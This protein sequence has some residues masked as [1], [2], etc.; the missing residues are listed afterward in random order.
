MSF[1]GGSISQAVAISGAEGRLSAVEALAETKVALSVYDAKMA[2]ID[3]KDVAQDGRLSAVEALAS[4]KVASATYSAKMALVDAKDAEHDGKLIALEAKDAEHSA[5]LVAIEAKDVEQDG[6]LSAVEGRA[7]ALETDISGRVQT[8]IDEKVAQTVFD[9]LASELRSADSAL[10]AALATKVAATTQ[11]S[12]D[13]LQDGAISTKASIASLNNV[14]NAFNSELDRLDGVDATKVAIVDYEA[15][16]DAL[17]EFINVLLQTYTITK[18]TGGAYEYTGVKQNLLAP[19]FAPE[20]PINI[21]ASGN[22]LSFNLPNTVGQISF[23]DV[24][25]GGTWYQGWRSAVAPPNANLL[26]INGTTV[27]MVLPVNVVGGIDIFT[28]YDV[29]SGNSNAGF[30]HITV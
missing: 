30:A 23:V 21:V 24:N 5:R 29:F 8:A 16:V 4:S 18:P 13:A 28:R 22:A 6:R 1:T 9:S 25:V 15:K 10:T 11:A 14:I 26:S 7:T 27:A 20:N 2:L 12:V 3:A 17:E 19:P